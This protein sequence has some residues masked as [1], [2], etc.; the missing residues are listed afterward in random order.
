MICR[1]IVAIIGLFLS[2]IADAQQ[3]TPGNPTIGT[4]LPT[5][6]IAGRTYG[7]E[8]NVAPANIAVGSANRLYLVPFYIP[9][10]ST[11]KNLNF[12][13]GTGNAS[14]WHAAMC[15]YSDTSSGSVSGSLVANGD[16]G[17][18][19]VA[20]SGTGNIA[21]TL[22]GSNGIAVGAGWYW[23]GW[24]ADSAAE[25]VFSINQTSPL[26]FSVLGGAGPSQII[27]S[28]ISGVFIAQTFGACPATFSGVTYNN[29]A[30]TPYVAVG[31]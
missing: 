30:A 27:A 31:F 3:V 26:T 6:F 11:I 1:F 24:M 18:L 22:N 23:L 13:V 17:S 20:A 7:P 8:L 4:N 10:A 29:N 12:N 19:S 14:G 15:V 28:Y 21:G 9:T 5:G 2:Q 16:T 25:S